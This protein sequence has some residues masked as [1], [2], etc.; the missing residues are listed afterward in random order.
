MD[1]SSLKRDQ[2]KINS[3]EW[4]SDIPQMGNVRLKVRGLRSEAYK[5][6]LR[7]LM[8]AVPREKRDRDGSALPAAIEDCVHRAVH[9]TILLDWDGF[10]DE[11]K[12][13]RYNRDLAFKWLTDPAFS[14][15]AD[16]VLWAAGVVD[17]GRSAT[18]DALAK[19]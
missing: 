13:V 11:G 17:N 6:A 18:E 5:Q 9:E 10:T 12:Q 2:G 15:F 3:G 16:A 7:R 1:I 19:N 4:V 8:A 14:A